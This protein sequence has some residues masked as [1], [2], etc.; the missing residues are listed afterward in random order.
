MKNTR[1]T[2]KKK[3]LELAFLY[4]VAPKKKDGGLHM[5]SDRSRVKRSFQFFRREIWSSDFSLK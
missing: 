2:M 4:N 1:K 5:C 3:E